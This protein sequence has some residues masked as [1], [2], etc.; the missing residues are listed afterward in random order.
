MLR[1]PWTAVLRNQ[2]NVKL[3]MIPFNAPGPSDPQV[4]PTS[5]Q[6]RGRQGPTS[7]C[8][9][10]WSHRETSQPRGSV[11]VSLWPSLQYFT[12][13]NQ[14][15]APCCDLHKAQPRLT[16]I[17][18]GRDK[19]QEHRILSQHPLLTTGLH[20]SAGSAAQAWLED[21]VQGLSFFGKKKKKIRA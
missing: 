2:H 19:C 8:D 13:H 15:R 17:S 7:G 10:G 16:F 6:V 21:C 9:C 5:L 14:L 1:P 20:P 4:P 18:I 3:A 12:N 11:V